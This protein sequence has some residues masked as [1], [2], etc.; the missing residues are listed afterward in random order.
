MK[1]GDYCVAV[2]MRALDLS[3][4]VFI[5]NLAVLFLDQFHLTGTE[6]MYYH[7][8]CFGPVHSVIE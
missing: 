7:S 3:Y 5:T 8:K 2:M 6:V 4:L 1:A